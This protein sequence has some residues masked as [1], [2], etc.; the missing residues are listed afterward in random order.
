MSQLRYFTAGESHG[1][2]LVGILEGMPAGLEIS[3]AEIA[4]Q[5]QRRQRGHG[6]GGRMRLEQDHARILSGVRFGKTLGSPIALQ[7]E[8]RDWPNWQTR[9]AVAPTAGEVTPVEIPRPGHADLAGGIKYQTD[10]LRNVLERASA[11]ETAMRVALGAVARKFLASFHLRLLSHV[12]QIQQARSRYSFLQIGQPAFDLPLDEIEARSEASPVRCLDEEAGR[13]M[14]AC[15]DQARAARDTVGG[16][17]EVA[18]LNV[19]VGLGSHVQWDRRLDARLAAA[20]MSIP[21]IKGVEIGDAFAGAGSRGSAFHDPIHYTAQRGF[22]RPS[23]HAGG[24]EGGITNGEPLVVRAAKKPISTLMRP[25]ESVN[26]RTKAPAAAHIERSDV[27]AVPAA[28]VIGEAMMALVLADALL[29][30]FGGDSMQE[31]L[32]RW[33]TWS[34]SNR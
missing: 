20:F 29:E 34:H 25:L 5:L 33:T 27:C 12:V 32:E 31:I 1:Q 19:P 30:K 18:A 4:V 28:A 6:R 23:N 2:V 14:I 13:E 9:M 10:D 7:I 8:N 22:H 26:L 3:E 16:I 21:A 11:R 15:I 24:L 17:F